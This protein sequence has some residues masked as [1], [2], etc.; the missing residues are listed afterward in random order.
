MHR[1]QE[2]R[3]QHTIEIAGRMKI[4]LLATNAAWHARPEQRVIVDALTCVRE[5]VALNRSGP[6]VDAQRRTASEDPSG[7]DAP[8]RGPPSCHREQR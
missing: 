1:D 4:P 3:N 5:K 7:D 8:V 6:A 2:A